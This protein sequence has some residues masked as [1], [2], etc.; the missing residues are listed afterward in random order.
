MAIRVKGANSLLWLGVLIISAVIIYFFFIKNGRLQQF[1]DQLF[2]GI[3]PVP[4]TTPPPSGGDGQISTEGTCPTGGETCEQDDQGRYDCNNANFDSYEATWCGSFSN[5]DLTIKLYGPNHSSSGDC[6]WC[7]LHITP[8]NGLFKSGGEGPHPG[9]NCDDYGDGEAIGTTDNICVKA[10]MQPGPTMIGYAL[11]NGQWKEMSRYTGHCGCEEN[12]MQRT[13]NQVTFRCDGSFNTT[14]ATV[15][16]LGAGGI[17]PATPSASNDG[18]GDGNEDEPAAPTTTGNPNQQTGGTGQPNSTTPSN[19]SCPRNR[20][21]E[22]F[23]NSPQTFEQCCNTATTGVARSTRRASIAR[24]FT[25]DAYQRRMDRKKMH[26][27]MGVNIGS[28]RARRQ[29]VRL[30]NLL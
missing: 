23:C 25:Y 22:A 8:G 3:G 10:V 24:D 5:D 28:I 20:S 18:D 27:D 26:S 6:C 4:T 12:S 21:C 30:G 2:S 29:A 16:Q 14:C 9:G 7:V 19:C 1:I 17:T 13:G 11:M 15:K